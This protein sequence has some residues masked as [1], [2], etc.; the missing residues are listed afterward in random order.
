M[1]RPTGHRKRI[2]HFDDPGHVHEL[3]FSCYQRWPLLTDDVWRG[4]LAESIDRAVDGHRYRLAAFV[5]MP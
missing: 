2:R 1:N 3:T 4:M 5:F